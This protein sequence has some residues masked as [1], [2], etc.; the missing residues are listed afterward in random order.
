MN[1]KMLDEQQRKALVWDI[2]RGVADRVEPFVWQTDTCIGTWHYNRPV[3]DKHGYKT[4]R[5]R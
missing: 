2:E 4:R 1:T 3:Y 5:T